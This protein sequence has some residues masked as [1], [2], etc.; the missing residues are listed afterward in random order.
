MFEVLPEAYGVVF[1]RIDVVAGDEVLSVDIVPGAVVPEL[2]R[3]RHP[4]P[5]LRE[6][7]VG[8]GHHAV[9]PPTGLPP[10]LEELKP[11]P[12]HPIIVPPVQGEEP[13]QAAL[14]HS[15]HETGGDAPHRRPPPGDEAAQ[16]LLEPPELMPGEY[17]AEEAGE[18]LDNAWKTHDGQHDAINNK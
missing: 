9:P 4:P 13:V 1:I 12:V 2:P 16:V 6:D 15:L 14:V 8:Y 3:P 5:S 18:L 7:G 17:P 11:P 10:G